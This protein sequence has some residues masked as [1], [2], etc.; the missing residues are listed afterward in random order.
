[1]NGIFGIIDYSLK[2]VDKKRIEKMFRAYNYSHFNHIKKYEAI[3]C[4]LYSFIHSLSNEDLCNEELFYDQFTDSVILADAYIYNRDELI[5]ILDIPYAVSDSELLLKA[6]NKWNHQCIEFI[7]GDFIFLIHDFKSNKT[8]IFRDQVGKNLL[9]YRLYNN[10]LVFSSNIKGILEEADYDI[11]LNSTWI[12][13]YFFEKSSIVELDGVE[14][15]Y[16]TILQVPPSTY[17]EITNCKINNVKYWNPLTKIKKL[18]GEKDNILN[19]LFNI[20]NDSVT[21][22]INLEGKIAIKLSGGLDSNLVAG[23]A[24]RQLSKENKVLNTYTATPEKQFERE[25]G[26]SFISNEK[27]YASMINEIYPNISMSFEESKNA[28]ALT[29]I[30]AILDVLEQPYKFIQNSHWIDAINKKVLEDGNSLILSGSYGNASLSFGEFYPYINNLIASGKIF[31]ATK[32][33][34]KYSENN[35]KLCFRHIKSTI[36]AISPTFRCNRININESI[37]NH[38]IINQVNLLQIESNRLNSKFRFKLNVQSYNNIR[39]SNVSIKVLSHINHANAK[40]ELYTGIIQRDPT[41]DKNIIEYC[42]SIPDEYFNDDI[43]DRQIIRSIGKGIV[44]NTILELHH[45]RG[46]QGADW[47][48]RIEDKLLQ[49]TVE[50]DEL[51]KSRELNKYI[52]QESVNVIILKLQ[53]MGITNSTYM[54]VHELISIIIFGKF[55]QNY[56]KERRERYER[57]D[58]TNS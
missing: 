23:L 52:S 55:L 51:M 32:L 6:Y 41:M 19:D 8:T 43:R 18:K 50:L 5:N 36:K 25:I 49:I 27:K 31:K 24:A 9:Y 58:K 12:A 15:V 28:D 37:V 47:V 40:Y 44:P 29:C 22:R 14:T 7:D 2:N 45:K 34:Y 53:K 30:D 48:F 26:K 13:N 38:S 21:K 10:K 42:Y 33:I 56:T 35:Y 4:Y 3:N 1:M 54:Y 57:V 46:F 11:E 16:E 39:E 20:C 17:I